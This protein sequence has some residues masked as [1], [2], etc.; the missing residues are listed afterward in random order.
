MSS[1]EPWS[2]ASSWRTSR[3]RYPGSASHSRWTPART[4]AESPLFTLA[5]VLGGVIL[6]QGRL[7]H[8]VLGQLLVTDSN[9]VA[10]AGASLVV[11]ATT[12]QRSV[13]G[14]MALRTLAP[15]LA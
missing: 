12:G 1:T 13:V 5:R 2:S 3:A 14:Q 9:E 4:L 15:A 7:G 10:I 11:A 6:M 8:Q